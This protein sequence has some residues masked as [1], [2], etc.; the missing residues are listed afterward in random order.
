MLLMKHHL[1]LIESQQL[2]AAKADQLLHELYSSVEDDR[3][4]LTIQNCGDHLPWPAHQPFAL[5]WFFVWMSGEFSN[6]CQMMKVLNELDLSP[7]NG[8]QTKF[9]CNQT[10]AA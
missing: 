1:H 5:S 7:N 8:L 2:G 6:L 10:M 4:S 3:P 9:L